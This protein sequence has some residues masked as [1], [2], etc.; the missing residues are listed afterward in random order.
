MD[1]LNREASNF[2]LCED[3]PF[4]I[5]RHFAENFRAIHSGRFV[6]GKGYF[7]PSFDARFWFDA[8]E[9]LAKQYHLFGTKVAL[10]PHGAQY[11]LD[12]E[13]FAVDFF[14]T[15]FAHGR[16][17]LTLRAPRAA[18]AAMHALFPH[19]PCGELINA[20]IKTLQLQITLFSRLRRARMVVLEQLSTASL[21]AIGEDLGHASLLSVDNSLFRPPTPPVVTFAPFAR[22]HEGCLKQLDYCYK[23]LLSDLIKTG[24]VA[25][26][27]RKQILCDSL[28]RRLEDIRANPLSTDADS[29]SPR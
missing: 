15:Y 11:W 6:C 19:L 3:T 22:E 16:Y 7:L 21:Q 17:L 28:W 5:S 25:G 29:T 26:H 4:L 20:W 27:V 23:T 2:I 9:T 1:I 10:G 24:D 12:V 13:R 18:L 8:Y 14:E